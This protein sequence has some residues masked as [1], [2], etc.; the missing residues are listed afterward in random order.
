MHTHKDQMKMLKTNS[1]AAFIKDDMNFSWEDDLFDRDEEESVAMRKT[2]IRFSDYNA[3]QEIPCIS[4]MEASEIADVWYSHQFFATMEAE[5]RELS[6]SAKS[7]RI[8]VSNDICLRGLEEKLHE[9]QKKIN[10]RES[11]GAI[12]DEQGAQF[13]YG[14]E[15][16]EIIAQVYHAFAAHCN[17]EAVEMARQDET[18]AFEIYRISSS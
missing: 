2:R 13:G 7:G 11:I 6:R 10:R 3:I 8:E 5:C 9:S 17:D 18:I 15:S 14:E 12:V 16:A 4:D 1:L